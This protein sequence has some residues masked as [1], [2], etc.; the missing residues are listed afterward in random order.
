MV[1]PRILSTIRIVNPAPE[2]VCQIFTRVASLALYYKYWLHTLVLLV[3]WRRS[4]SLVMA[5]AK[6]SFTYIDGVDVS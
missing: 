3:L 6:E 1:N 5:L 4:L 2:L